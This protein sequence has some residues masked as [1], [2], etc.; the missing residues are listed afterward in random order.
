MGHKTISDAVSAIS[1][2][3]LLSFPVIV[4]RPILQASSSAA[5]VVRHRCCPA[6]QSLSAAV[7]FPPSQPS[8]PLSCLW[9]L[10]SPSSL[11]HC[12]LPL[13]LACLCCQPLTITAAPCAPDAA[14]ALPAVAAPLP[15]C[16]RCHRAAVANTVLQ[17]LLPCCSPPPRCCRTW[18]CP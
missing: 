1:C 15:R 16:Q 8:S 13:E 5:I 9:C 3:L 12:S 10:L 11:P 7:V 14:F 18:S 4:C 6:S 17:M 2:R